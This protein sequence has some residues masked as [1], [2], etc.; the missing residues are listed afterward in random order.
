MTKLIFNPFSPVPVSSKS[1]VRGWALHWA[2]SL[3]AEVADKETDIHGYDDLYL[4]HGVNFGGA[5]NLFGGV[6]PEVYERLLQLVTHEGQLFSLDRPM[7]DYV[8]QLAKRVGQDT[9]DPRLPKL[10]P[11]LKE[12]F[13]SAETV[14]QTDLEAK[15]LVIGDSHATAY[16]PAGAAISRHNGRTLYG[17]MEDDFI[18]MR[19]QA[20]DCSKYDHVLMVLGSIDIRHHIGRQENPDDAV[21]RLAD[22]Y[23]HHVKSL[24]GEFIMDIEVAAPVPVEHEGRRIPQTG[25]YMK[26]PFAGSAEQRRGWTKTFITRLQGHDI[27]VVQPPDDWYSMDGQ[28]Y[29]KT[30]MELGSSVHISP[31]HYR[32]NGWGSGSSLPAG[33]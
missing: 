8:D 3:K 15:T 31:T 2:E 10:L 11:V 21:L 6:S 1:H 32:R 16:A 28:L 20:I 27:S 24:M 5:L 17:A 7:P 9:C 22:R 26:T 29:A 4:D 14:L 25:F 23:A 19:L 18:N 33:S 12:R 13:E 30:C